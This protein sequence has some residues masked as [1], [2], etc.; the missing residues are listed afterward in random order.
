[1]SLYTYNFK[2]DRVIDGDSVYGVID[3]GFDLKYEVNVRLSLYDA[4]EIRRPASDEEREAGLRIK[5]FLEQLIDGKKLILKSNKLAVYC[6][7]E[8]ELYIAGELTSINEQVIQFI[9]ENRLEKWRF[10]Q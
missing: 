5:E 1:V 10:R 9:E 8:G 6:R 2:C 7:A 4:A 3:L